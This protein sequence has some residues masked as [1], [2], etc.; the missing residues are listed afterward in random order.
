MFYSPLCSGCVVSTAKA[1]SL[2]SNDKS[3]LND[4]CEFCAFEVDNK[5]VLKG[6]NGRYL[7]RWHR[8]GVDSIEA[9]VDGVNEYCKFIPQV[10][11]VI[12][13]SFDIIDVSWDFITTPVIYNPTVVTE[14]TYINDSSIVI[15]QVF[16]LEWTNKPRLN[17]DNNMEACMGI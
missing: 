1:W 5:L 8:D 2:S 14:D 15:V 4:W 17:R 6:H 16:D 3:F 11:D 12:P 10:G 7:C 9:S 13:P